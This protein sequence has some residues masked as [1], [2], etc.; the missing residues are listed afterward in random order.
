MGRPLAIALALGAAVLVLVGTLTASWWSSER[1]RWRASMGLQESRF[2]NDDTC[3]VGPV[4]GE[5]SDAQWVRAG[6]ASYAGGFVAG[7][8]LL[9]LVVTAATRRERD[10]LTKTTMVASASALVS[11]VVYVWLAPSFPEMTPDYSMYTYF[12]GSALGLVAGAVSLRV[13]ARAASAATPSR[14]S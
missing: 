9:A 14:D 12:A 8:L 2:C 13:A 6:S 7:G 4:G 10:L 3:R 11:A 5:A 1:N